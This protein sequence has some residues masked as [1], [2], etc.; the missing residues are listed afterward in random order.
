MHD[1][2]QPVDPAAGRPIEESRGG[3]ALFG[4]LLTWSMRNNGHRR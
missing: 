2:R 1:R 3:W 4:R